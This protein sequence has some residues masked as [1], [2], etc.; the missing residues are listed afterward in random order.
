MASARRST[1]PEVDQ[2][3]DADPENVARAI[4]LRLL[5]RAP[6]TRAQLA[7]ALA[8]R[9]VPADVA[10]RVLDRLTEVRLIDDAAFAE[11]WVSSRHAGRGLASR[12]LGDELRR[13][14]VDGVVVDQALGRLD[15]EGERATARALVNRRLRSTAGIDPRKRVSRLVGMLCRK[16]YPPGVAMAVVRD[17]LADEGSDVPDC[18]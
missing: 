11:A 1:G 5:T 18:D 4:C 8:K 12:A 9:S 13:R 3:P 16:G 14:G 6:R 15:A 17:A 7:E 10:D 2:S